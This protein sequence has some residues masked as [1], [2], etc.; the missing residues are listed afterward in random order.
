MWLGNF[1]MVAV[2]T[3]WVCVLRNF[4][5][6]VIELIGEAVLL[7]RGVVVAGIVMVTFDCGNCSII[8]FGKNRIVKKQT[9]HR[10]AQ[11]NT[12]SM[13]A[14]WIHWVGFSEGSFTDLWFDCV[15]LV[16]D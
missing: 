7:G 14:R 11:L 3:S 5:V 4:S 6:G 9:P 10:T 15:S 1:S 13:G 8:C 2:L 12:A 16:I